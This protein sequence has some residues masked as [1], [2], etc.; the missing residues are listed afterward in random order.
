[1]IGQFLSSTREIAMTPASEDLLKRAPDLPAI[2]RTN[3]ADRL[4]LSLD[5][6][7]EAIDNV[8][9]EEIDKRLG[10]YRAGQ[11]ETIACKWM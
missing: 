3:L 9:R 4:L 10:A 8:W 6:P 2:E 11:A 1:M 7:D 5:R